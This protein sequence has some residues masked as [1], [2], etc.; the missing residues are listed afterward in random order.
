MS[1]SIQIELINL[2]AK[3]TK[4]AL[5]TQLKQAKYYSIILDCTPDISETLVFFGVLTQLYSL[6]S[7][8]T[9]RWT[10]LKKNVPL[11]L[12]SQLATRWKS[13]INCISPLWYHLIEVI[14][15]LKELE[16]YCF[17][18]KEMVKQSM[19]FVY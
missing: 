11:S 14:K 19:M 7:S 5:L 16:N 13:R 3:E 18:K 12:K 4:N 1:K 15:A 2:V 10:I 8:S 9:Q 17:E 6:F